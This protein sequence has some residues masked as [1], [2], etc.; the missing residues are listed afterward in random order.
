ME[1]SRLVNTTGYA[2][3]SRG[4]T[5][6]PEVPMPHRK[7][8]T[9]L[10]RAAV[11]TGQSAL[12]TALTLSARW[13]I[14]AAGLMNPTAASTREWNTAVTEKV[15]A[16]MEGAVALSFG[17]QQAMIRCAFRPPTPAGLAQ[18]MLDLT[19]VALAPARRTVKANARRLN[20]PSKG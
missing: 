14:L 17:W 6:T 5:M 10:T 16:A 8:H 15:T 12:D 9:S 2:G 4:R 11:E 19:A 3:P 7:L 20:R 1:P 18:D 13:P